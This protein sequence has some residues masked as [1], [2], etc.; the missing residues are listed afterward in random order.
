MI[1]DILALYHCIWF[2]CLLRILCA[3]QNKNS[4]ARCFWDCISTGLGY[5]VQTQSKQDFLASF[6][7]FFFFLLSVFVSVSVQRQTL[8]NIVRFS[9]PLWS[10]RLPVTTAFCTTCQINPVCTHTCTRARTHVHMSQEMWAS[11]FSLTMVNS[12]SSKTNGRRAEMRLLT[13]LI[14]LTCSRLCNVKH[15]LFTLSDCET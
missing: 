10:S 15:E 1:S 9:F 14:R 7:F 11:G 13:S 12:S 4:L 3:R 8:C 6:T 2:I 5:H